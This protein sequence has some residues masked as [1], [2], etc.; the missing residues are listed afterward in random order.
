VGPGLFRTLGL[1]ADSDL[2]YDAHVPED[3]LPIIRRN[4]RLAIFGTTGSGK[5][6]LAHYLWR[7]IPNRLPDPDNEIVGFWRICIDVTD[8]VWDDALT[9]YDPL[10]I[11]WEDASSLRFVPDIDTLEDDISTLYNQ[12]MIHGYCFIWLDEANEVT[13]AHHIAPGFRKTLLQG[14]KAQVGNA[15][16]T[17]RPVDINKSILTQSEHQF[18]FQLI[19]EGDRRRI[20]SNIGMTLQRFDEVMSKLPGHSYLWFSVRE[21][22]LYTMPALPKE[23]VDFL[24]G[25]GVN[26][27]ES[28][29]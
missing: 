24:D 19:D 18:I 5:S 3:R 17:P 23:V 12:V 29:S 25:V 13:S 10:Q 22:T 9:F 26:L 6:V 2:C 8:S 28:A 11:P 15:S 1:D 16:V 4:D 20:A 7:T 14:R 27:A 21:R